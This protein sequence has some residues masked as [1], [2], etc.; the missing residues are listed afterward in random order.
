VIGFLRFVGILNAAVWFGGAV[1]FTFWSGRAPFS[2]E[3]KALLG[4]QNYPYFSGAI[5]QILIARYFNLQFTCSIIAILHLLAEWLYLGRFPQ[6]ARLALLLGLC[7]AVLA[8]GYWL[9]PRMKALHAIKYAQNQPLPVR[10]SASRSFGAWHGV[11]MGVNLLVVAGLA[12]YLWRVAN[13]S[14]ET[15][16]VSAVKFRG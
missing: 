3:M 7:L 13:S 14:D 8:G 11:S 1:F 2:P 9:Q 5:A 6:N 15:R 12:V 10:E 4:P 16:F